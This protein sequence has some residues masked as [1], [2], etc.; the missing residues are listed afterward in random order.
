MTAETVIG[1]VPAQ[2]EFRTCQYTGLKVD[3]AAQTL[4]KVNAV[5]AVIFLAI[6]GVMVL[7]A[8]CRD[9]Y[10]NATF[11]DWFRFRD[12]REFETELRKRYE[13]NGQ[14]AFA[15]LDKAQR[16]RVILVSALPPEEVATMGMVPA[17]SLDDAMEKAE[18]LLPENWSAYVIPQGGT[19]LPVMGN[20]H[21]SA[22][23]V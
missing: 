12:L 22:I 3:T 14:T 23:S 20:A 2:T 4:I 5:A 21:F 10:G 17:K 6:G 1:V 16:F 8:E 19:V 13:I 9:G 11:F 18:H 15:T 7:L